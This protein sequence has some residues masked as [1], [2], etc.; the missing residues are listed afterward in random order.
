MMGF[1]DM[2]FCSRWQECAAGDECHRALTD[3]VR[4][5]AEEWMTDAP[6]AVAAFVRCFV[7]KGEWF[8][9]VSDERDYDN[10]RDMDVGW[11]PQCCAR[12]QRYRWSNGVDVTDWRQGR[13]PQYPRK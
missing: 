11:R 2:T 10:W 6:I 13:V 8:I 9:Q 4:A 12:C 7:P 5:E 3:E 1:R